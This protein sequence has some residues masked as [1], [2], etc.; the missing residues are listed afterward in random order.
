MS[1]ND[2]ANALIMGEGGAP[3]AKFGHVG[4][5]H[6]GRIV[7][8]TT[9]QQKSIKGELLTWDDGSPKMMAVLTI[10]TDERDPSIEDDDGK[11]RLFVKGDMVRAVREAVRGAGR[12]MVEL[13]G[14]VAVQYTGDGQARGVG[15][16]PPKLYRAGYKPP[17]VAVDDLMAPAAPAP[18]PPAPAPAPAYPPPAPAPAPAYPPPAPAPQPAAQQALRPAADDLLPS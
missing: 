6:R 1:M 13:G 3:T 18:A 17:A 7:E 9:R 2:D 4:D 15:Y 16:N 11:R 12:K 5:T 8:M 14:E 10:Q